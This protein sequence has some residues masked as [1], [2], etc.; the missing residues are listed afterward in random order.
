MF[1]VSPSFSQLP[2]VLEVPW[3]MAALLKSLP[4]PRVFFLGITVSVPSHG[5][6]IKT[7]L[8]EFTAHSNPG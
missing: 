7:P 4:L 6:L 1:L 3:I 8:M 5:P 2:A